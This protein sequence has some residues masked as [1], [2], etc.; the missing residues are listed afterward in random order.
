MKTVKA[1]KDMKKGAARSQGV[2]LAF[3]RLTC[4]MNFMVSFLFSSFI[5][6]NSRTTFS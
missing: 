2:V 3:M 4:Y 5:T 6:F 1:M